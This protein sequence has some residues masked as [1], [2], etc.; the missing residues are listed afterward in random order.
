M[1]LLYNRCCFI[2]SFCFLS[3][4]K[5]YV[6]WIEFSVNLFLF[7]KNILNLFHSII[8]NNQSSLDWTS[9]MRQI[10]FF[11]KEIFTFDIDQWFTSVSWSIAYCWYCYSLLFLMDGRLFS[12]INWDIR[13]RKIRIFIGEKMGHTQKENKMKSWEWRH[14]FSYRYVLYK[15]AFSL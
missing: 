2:H 8:R 7:A 15:L 10:N 14:M 13:L 3:E 9:S 1:Y 12:K 6:E 11:F 5:L 4:E